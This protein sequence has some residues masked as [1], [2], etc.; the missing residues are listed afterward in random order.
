MCGPIRFGEGVWAVG[1]A[2]TRNT[3]LSPVSCAAS[4]WGH[5]VLQ[6]V[7]CYRKE[8]FKR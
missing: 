6:V 2:L 5:R 8:K 7:A 3:R 4:A 1:L